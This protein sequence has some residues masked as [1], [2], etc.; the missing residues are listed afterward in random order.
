MS[1]FED[2]SAGEIEQV[3]PAVAKAIADAL[4]RDGSEVKLRSRLI[5][6]LDAESIDLLDVVFRLERAFKIK[7]PRGKILDEARGELSE[8]E[9]E[10]K[11]ILTDAGRER[12]RRYMSE[13]AAEDFPKRMKV[14]E[15]P[16]LFTVETFCKLVVRAI[17]RQSAA[18]A[19]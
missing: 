17:R 8:S 2:V 12:L 5:G 6:D 4:A 11:G 14:S 16:A 1:G 10:H 3:Y 7:I 18:A 15:L 9:F 19:S 13:I